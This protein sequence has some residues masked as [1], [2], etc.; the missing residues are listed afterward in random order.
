[1]MSGRILTALWPFLKLLQI[2]GG[3]PIAKDDS[4]PCGYKAL[5]SVA[6]FI[7]IVCVCIVVASM[8][9]GFFCYLLYI[10]GLSVY[11]LMKFFNVMKGSTVYSISMS[12]LTCTMWTVTITI[13]IG[14][15]KFKNRFIEILQMFNDLDLQE[16]KPRRKY[17]LKFVIASWFL[18]FIG[19]FSPNFNEADIEMDLILT[20]LVIFLMFIV[21]AI[22]LAP[23]LSFIILYSE[24]CNKLNIWIQRLIRDFEY[25][26]SNHWGTIKECS[27]LL[28]HGLKKTNSTFSSLLFW[29][30]LLYLTGMIFC[31][32]LALFLSSKLLQGDR[33]N[34]I[35][36]QTL[37]LSAGTNAMVQT[38][39][40]INFL[41]YDVSRNLKVLKESISDIGSEESMSD[42]EKGTKGMKCKCFQICFIFNN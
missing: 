36:I 19:T 17:F 12:G 42:I 26:Q 3:C 8:K 23:I 9:L 4:N 27:Y 30:S 32:Y 21:Q 14:N 34:D 37:M 16:Y 22:V 6:Y 35:L 15:F 13:W 31:A 5:S 2:M 40:Y 39:F 11:Q 10:R 18:C 24:G 29:I 7:I 28:K 41:S 38:I 1:M 33:S 25:N 20:L